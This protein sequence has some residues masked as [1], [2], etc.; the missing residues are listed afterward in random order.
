MVI[1]NGVKC[2]IYAIVLALLMFINSCEAFGI[3]V[4]QCC[5]E[6]QITYNQRNTKALQQ[7]LLQ[8]G[9]PQLSHNLTTSF[10]D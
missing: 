3:V 7:Y 8:F 6:T 1:Q 9:S 4:L 2:C 10:V 5:R